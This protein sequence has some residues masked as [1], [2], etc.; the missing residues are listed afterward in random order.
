MCSDAE[1]SPMSEPS[2]KNSKLPLVVVTREE[3]I[4][5]PLPKKAPPLV[6]TL[7]AT[8]LRRM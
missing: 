2:K 8:K 3:E 7:R 4:T 5:T 6:E 1:D